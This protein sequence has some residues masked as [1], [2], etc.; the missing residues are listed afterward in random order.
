[1]K[2]KVYS[3][4]ARIIAC[5]IAVCSL[6]AAPAGSLAAFAADSSSSV[7]GA[8]GAV[9]SD[10][11]TGAYEYYLEDGM[12]KYWIDLGG[13]DLTLHCFFRSGDPEYREEVYSLPLEKAKAFGDTLF[14]EEVK[15]GHDID[16]ASQFALF[17]ITFKNGKAFLTVV[18]DEKTLA[19]GP[20]GMLM[21]GC[22]EM[23]AKNGAQPGASLPL[24]LCRMAQA[25]YERHKDYYP[26]VAEFTDNGDGT[27]TIHLFEIVDDGNGTTHTATSAWYTVDAGGI[28]KD[29]IMGDEVNLRN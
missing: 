5:S 23:S 12:L 19:G 4:V 20:E 14:F 24:I 10:R 8:A 1:M 28:G 26:P 22:Y 17:A 11:L 6:F 13:D 15:N 29:D 2:S 25:Y 16:I 3:V 21:T 7:Q 9:E 27:Y 18:R